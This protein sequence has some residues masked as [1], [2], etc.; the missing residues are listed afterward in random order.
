MSN[1]ELLDRLHRIHAAVDATIEGDL[2]KF[3]PTVVSD[4]RG[5]K[6][7]QDFLGGLTDAQITNLAHGLIHNIANV[8][9]HLRRWCQK[10][11]HDP[12]RIDQ[13]LHAKAPRK[14]CRV[15]AVGYRV[16]IGNGSA[17]TSIFLWSS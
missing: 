6:M 2:A 4:E 14:R 5:F 9:D 15:V 10:N 1:D 7:Y 13:M 11:G 12:K 3:P 16:G 8:P 17:R